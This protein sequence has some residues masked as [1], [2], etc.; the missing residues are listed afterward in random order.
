M[1]LVS[2]TRNPILSGSSPTLTCTVELDPTVDVSVDITTVWS[3]PDGSTLMSDASPVM[4]SFTH[5]TSKLTLN[6]VEL[7]DSG[8]YTCTVSIRGKIRASVSKEVVISKVLLDA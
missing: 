7:S 4:K 6:Y 3:G 2:I 8:N 1:G 5:Y